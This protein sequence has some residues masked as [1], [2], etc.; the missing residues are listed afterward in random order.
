MMDTDRRKVCHGI[1]VF[2]GNQQLTPEAKYF[3][4]RIVYLYGDGSVTEKVED[5]AKTVGLSKAALTKARSLLSDLGYIEVSAVPNFSK[6]RG[7]RPRF[8]IRIKRNFLDEICSYADQQSNVVSQDH[9]QR[10]MD[11]LLFWPSGRDVL[12]A[13]NIKK[14]K[15]TAEESSTTHTFTITTRLLLAVLYSHADPCGVVIKLG[16]SRLS[17]LLGISGDR[18]ESQLKII[19]NLGYLIDRVSGVT[20]R[21]IFGRAAG[22]FYMNISDDDCK[23]YGSFTLVAFDTNVINFYNER[24]WGFRLGQY[25]QNNYGCICDENHCNSEAC[26]VMETIDKLYNSSTQSSEYDKTEWFKKMD[27]LLNSIG[28]FYEIHKV[29]DDPI[30]CFTGIV[31]NNFLCW[32]N[33][34]F[35]SSYV[36]FLPIV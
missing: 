24:Y 14:I 11:K 27:I 5:L 13:R 6:E 31:H 16:L 3:L 20:G 15:K 29:I 23:A 2:G 30:D 10:L 35:S 4:I 22:T 26:F 18:L 12:R 28:N 19:K 8:Q 25:Y 34:F 33:I 17:R 32:F 7:G 9:H 36:I 21:I 1:L